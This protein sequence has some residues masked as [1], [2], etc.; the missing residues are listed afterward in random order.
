MKSLAS[1][2]TS[3]LRHWQRITLIPLF[4]LL[5]ACTDYAPRSGGDILVLGD[6][7]M[8]WNSSA[9][10]SIPDVIGQ[11]LAR[12]VVSKAVPGAQFDNA[13]TVA[14]AVGFDVRRQFPGGRWNWVVMNG[15]AND[16]NSDCGCGACGPVVDRLITADAAGGSIP[17]FV[18]AVLD[19]TG[20]QVVWSGYYAGSGKGSFAGCRGDLVELERRIARFAASHPRVTFLDAEDVIDPKNSA[21]FAGDN[22]H[23][24]VKGSALIAN[25][26]AR[27]IR[28]HEP[29]TA[30]RVAD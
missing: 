29:R 5:A 13:S 12:T 8:A 21:L 3:L 2:S 25:G 18:Q 22:T 30:Q 17:L 11:Q 26:I 23:P 28:A 20:G 24:S 4:A 14:G 1:P 27:H 6:S 7:I 15:G 19:A 9:N 16:L 10:A